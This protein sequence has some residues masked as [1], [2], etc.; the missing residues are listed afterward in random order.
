MD[1]QQPK[2]GEGFLA[3]VRVGQYHIRLFAYQT[4]IGLGSNVYSLNDHRWLN[5][6]PTWAVTFDDA[7][8]NAESLARGYLRTAANLQLPAVEWKPMPLRRE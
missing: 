8:S 3:D 1:S 6:G 2:F 5:A 7:R 4:E